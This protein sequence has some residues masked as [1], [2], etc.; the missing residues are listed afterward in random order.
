MGKEAKQKAEEDDARRKSEL[1]Q[2]HKELEEK[3]K[4]AED[5]ARFKAQE[6]EKK[7]AEVEA[8]RQA[9]EEARREA[10]TAF[11]ES[12]CSAEEEAQ[13]KVELEQSQRDEAQLKGEL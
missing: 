12:D 8:L 2:Y 1:E 6:A 7:K 10:V 13:R 9:Q 5:E 3:Q 11:A 4:K